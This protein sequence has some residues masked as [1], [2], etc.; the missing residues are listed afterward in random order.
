MTPTDKEATEGGMVKVSREA[1]PQAKCIGCDDPLFVRDVGIDFGQSFD[2]HFQYDGFCKWCWKGRQ[3]ERAKAAD[4][5]RLAAVSEAEQIIFEHG[6][7]RG[8]PR[9]IKEDGS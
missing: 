8:W 6:R 5:D 7:S 1:L 9:D 2:R 3:K 4:Y